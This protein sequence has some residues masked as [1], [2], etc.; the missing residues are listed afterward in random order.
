MRVL[1]CEDETIIRLDLRAI[2]ERAGLE[3]VGEARDGVE[4]LRLAAE[5]EPDIVVMDVQMPKL[6]GI[7][8]ARQLLA[9]R[10]VPIVV[11]TAFPQ[12]ELVRRAVEAGVF[13]Y[14]VKPFRENDVL[15]AI[16]AARAR[17]EELQAV[18]AGGDLAG[19]GAREPQAGRAG[20]GH[21]DGPREDHRGGGL[22]SHPAGLAAD[23]KADADDRRGRHRDPRN[24]GGHV[25]SP[26]VLLGATIALT[27]VAGV[28]HLAVSDTAGTFASAIPLL[29]VAPAD[30]GRH[31]QPGR[32]ALAERGRHRRSR[33]SA[34]WR[35]WP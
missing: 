4:A 7:E 30:R 11:V 13:G 1:I 24:P 27:V 17:F 5:L 16:H 6:D 2:C 32:P 12:E 23:R 29:L 10:P 3:V 26:Y 21:A 34:T 20:Q 14:L 25:R 22:R 15:P 19:R 28:F 8:A 35:S 9:E 18:R 31:R 33:R